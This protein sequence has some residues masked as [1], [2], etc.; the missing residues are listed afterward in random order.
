MIPAS[1]KNVTKIWYTEFKKPSQWTQ[2]Q[3]EHIEKTLDVGKKE[4]N[5]GKVNIGTRN[6]PSK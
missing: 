3:W 4:K 5:I 1:A 2:K 6:I